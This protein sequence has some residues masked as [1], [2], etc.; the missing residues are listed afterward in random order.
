MSGLPDLRLGGAR[1]F[2]ARVSVAFFFILIVSGVLLSVPSRLTQ[3]TI[4]A[5]QFQGALNALGLSLSFLPV[6]IGLLDAIMFIA[7]FVVALVII[8]RRSDDRMTTFVSI[9]L[10]TYGFTTIRPAEALV[11]VG[12]N[13]HPLMDGVRGV[14]MGAILFFTF[15]FP[16]GR[17]VPRWTMYLGAMFGAWTI[18]YLVW[19]SSP[20]NPDLWSPTA[21]T[22]FFLAWFV[23]GLSAQVYRYQHQSTASQKQ[24]TKWVVLGLIAT[25][26]AYAIFFLTPILLA[27]VLDASLTRLIYVM[28]G[29]PVLYVGAIMFPLGLAFGI[30]RYRLWDINI[31]VSRTLAYTLLTITLAIIYYANVVLLQQIFR[32]L[33]GQLQSQVVT[34]L[35]TLA[36]AALFNPLRRR[37]QAGIDRRFNRHKYD[38][39][40]VLA[41]FAEAVRDETDPNQ[42]TA[43]LTQVISETV[44]PQSVSVWLSQGDAS[45]RRVEGRE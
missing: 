28:V 14:G 27:R 39:A 9:L 41:G 44:E 40:R 18:A 3:L 37:V 17:F 31:V 26:I 22:L 42:L 20:L 36:I 6:Y 21:R 1:L 43:R 24:Q 10:L 4:L 23:L 29:V 32:T 13:L 16:D 15:L 12:P 38:A 5:M 45:M 25:V 8:L 30:L 35:S 11:N 19:D 34:V 7:C 33:T 2:F